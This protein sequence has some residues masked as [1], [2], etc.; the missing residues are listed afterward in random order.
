MPKC[1]KKR[2]SKTFEVITVRSSSMTNEYQNRLLSFEKM[3]S[4]T[5]NKFIIIPAIYM[6]MKNDVKIRQSHNCLCSQIHCVSRKI[7]AFMAATQKLLKKFT[8]IYDNFE[9]YD[10]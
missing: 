7:V 1:R 5:E 6:F 8:K 2:T 9:F 3:I 10:V 4:R